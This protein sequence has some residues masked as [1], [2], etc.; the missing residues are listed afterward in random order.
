MWFTNQNSLLIMTLQIF[1]N[2][3]VKAHAVAIIW[4]LSLQFTGSWLVAVF[5]FLILCIGGSY[6]T[7]KMLAGICILLVTPH[8]SIASYIHTGSNLLINTDDAWL[9]FKVC[10]VIK[11]HLIM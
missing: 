8:H 2:Q 1:K 7:L 4:L 5:L 9:N 3:N 11:C 6:V 10:N